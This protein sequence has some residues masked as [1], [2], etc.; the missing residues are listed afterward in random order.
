[1]PF[2]LAKLKPRQSVGVEYHPSLRFENVPRGSLPSPESRSEALIEARNFKMAKSIHAYVRGSTLKFY[3]WL[4]ASGPRLPQG[5]AVWICGDCHLGNLGPTSDRR[6]GVEMQIR[7]LDQTVIGN[8]AHDLVR[9][10]LS[11]ASAVRASDLPGVTITL[12]IEALV[13][14]YEAALEG[15]FGPDAEKRDR[16]GAV[17]GVLKRAMRRGWRHLIEERMKDISPS[18]PL[19]PHFWPVTKTERH[20]LEQLCSTPEVR[21]MVTQLRGRQ[22]DDRIELVDAAYWVKGCSSLGR[23]RFAVLLRLNRS[24]LCLVDIKEAIAA[25]APRAAQAKMPRDNALRMVAGAAALSP[26]LGHRMM[27]ARF[28]GKAVVLRELTPQDL[29]LEIDQLTRAEAVSLAGYLAGVVGYAHGRQM[30]LESRRGW[31]ET[32]S[33]GRSAELNA[34]SWLWSSVVDLMPIHEVAYLEHCRAFASRE[35]A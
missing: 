11:L 8:P 17:K 3:E 7:D 22:P 4:E 1:M 14:G 15:N 33:D 21:K 18:I 28:M 29:K 23:L 35:T 13:A 12:M 24:D 27:A 5:P 34:P 30:S 10:G 25:A 31:L 19:G 26:S 6:G 32:L 9:L 16:P 2:R 20:K